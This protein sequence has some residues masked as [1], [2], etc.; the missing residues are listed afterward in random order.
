MRTI[1]V[2]FENHQGKKLSGLL[3]YPENYELNECLSFAIFAHCF[4]CSK[5][6]KVIPTISRAL[7]RLK[8]AVLRFDFTGLGQSEGDFADTNFTTNVRD[9]L[10]GVEYLKENY[11]SPSMIIGH[12]LGGAAVLK[13][14]G[15]VDSIKVVCVIGAPAEPSHVAHQFENEKKIIEQQGESGV[16]LAGRDFVIKKQF[17]DD[18]NKSD[19]SADI[20]NLKKALLVLHS[21]IDDTVGIENAASIFQSAKHPKS[22]ISLDQADHLLSRKEDAFYAGEVIGSWAKKYLGLE[23]LDTGSDTTRETIRSNV[24][25]VVVSNKK[26]EVYKT[27]LYLNGFSYIADEP[28]SVGGSDMGASPTSFLLGA[29]GSCTAIT[30]RMYANRKNW[31]L[32]K[33]EIRLHS[34]V[35]PGTSTRS[36]PI[37]IINREISLTGNLTTEQKNRLLEIANKCPVHKTLEG[38]IQVKSTLV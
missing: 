9:L 24:Q 33:V 11:Q 20:A 10:S 22:F 17:L 34:E 8:M 16:K 27:D 37:T 26:N 28:K 21:P 30:L 14:A 15:Q 36:I 32:E 29:L 38:D 4:T 23:S 3:D 2:N 35:N 19:L 31:D 25:G 18:L 7:T 6:L 13:A 12:S 5:N 1:R